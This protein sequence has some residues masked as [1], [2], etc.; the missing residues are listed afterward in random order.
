VALIKDGKRSF[1]H[2]VMKQK[3]AVVFGE[4]NYSCMYHTDNSNICNLVFSWL[5]IS[6]RF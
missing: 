4:Q 6:K 3:A 5:I 2:I 1:G